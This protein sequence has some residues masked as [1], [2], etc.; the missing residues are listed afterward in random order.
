MMDVDDPRQQPYHFAGGGCATGTPAG[1]QPPSAKALGKRKVV[2]DYHSRMD[3]DLPLGADFG[4]EVGEKRKRGG[5]VTAEDVARSD[6]ELARL[7]VEM[8]DGTGLAPLVLFPDEAQA[9]RDSCSTDT[10]CHRVT[11]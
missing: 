7:F 6:R 1:M 10:A 8:F 9:T 5:Y 2:E 3:V 11:E 4:I